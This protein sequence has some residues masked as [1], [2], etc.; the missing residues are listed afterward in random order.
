MGKQK[1]IPTST[2]S[3]GYVAKDMC[4]RNCN[5]MF[6]SGRENEDLPQ[7]LTVQHGKLFLN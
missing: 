2:P 6:L 3:Y 4:V 5:G 1:T 7:T